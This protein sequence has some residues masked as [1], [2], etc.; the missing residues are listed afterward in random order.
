MF[1]NL[2]MHLSYTKDDIVN[3][4]M[5][6]HMILNSLRSYRT[7]FHKDYGELVICCDAQNYWRRKIFPHYKSNR[8]KSRDA[9]G[10]DWNLLFDSLNKIRDEIREHLPYKVIRIDTC[11]ADDIIASICHKYGRFLGDDEKILIISGDK[12]FGQLQKY[13]NVYQYAPVQK[14]MIAI[15]NPESFRKEHIMLGDRSDGV[16]NFISDDDTF[17]ENKRQKP[18]RRDKISEWIYMDPEQFCNREMLRGYKR[19]QMLIDLGKIPEDLQNE[20]IKQFDFAECNDRSKIFDYFIKNRL[21]N[22]TES[23]SDF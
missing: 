10:L 11:E 18:L 1:S 8:K 12:D 5:L 6:R 3:E 19:N 22:L 9:S 15:N 4:E 14:K 7:K 21:G 2:M 23:I 20:C 13:S 17:I 16:P